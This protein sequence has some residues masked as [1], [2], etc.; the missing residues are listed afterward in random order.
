ME[1]VKT[2]VSQIII[3]KKH[4]E[5][6]GLTQDASQ[7]D[8]TQAFERL[9]KTLDPANNDNLDFFVEEHAAVVEAFNALKKTFKELGIK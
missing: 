1:F 2:K 6:L 7:E 3:M 5:T 9:N 8:I 4:Y